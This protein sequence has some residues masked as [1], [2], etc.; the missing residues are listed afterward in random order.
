M[1]NITTGKVRFSY[2]HLTQP[3]AQN[4]GQEPKYSTTVLIPKS[5]TATVQRI[6]EA[7]ELAKQDGKNNKWGGVIPPVLADPLHDGDGG[8]PSD[9]MPYGDECKGHWVLVAKCKADRKPEIVDASLQPI[10]SPSEIYSG[11]YGR[12]SLSF[13]PY[14]ASGKK[15]VGCGLGPVQKLEDGEPLGGGVTAASAFGGGIDP[16]T[17]APL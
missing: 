2:V 3:F 4:A 12:V 13:Y 16:I 7:V 6:R 5:D 15:G 17:G 14:D 8:R 1:A 9:G 11:M 10:L